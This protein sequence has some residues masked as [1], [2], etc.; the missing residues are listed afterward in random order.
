MATPLTDERVLLTLVQD[1]PEAPL[2]KDEATDRKP[3]VTVRTIAERT[4]RIAQIALL[5]HT[6]RGYRQLGRRWVDRYRD[7]YPQRIA[8][9]D[10]ALREAAGDVHAEKQL[11]DRR[12]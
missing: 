2:F 4:N 6:V 11:G 7:D 5:P 9:V 3:A 1:L 10:Q 8:T 12:E